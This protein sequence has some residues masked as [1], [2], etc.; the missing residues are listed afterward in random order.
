MPAGLPPGDE[1][2][3]RDASRFPGLFEG[4]LPVIP[5]IQ[6]IVVLPAIEWLRSEP[7]SKC[8]RELNRSQ[9]YSSDQLQAL[10]WEKLRILV[11]HC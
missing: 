7:I 6:R 11:D 5:V 10:Q 4:G 8:L 2:P 1:G 3:C 9:W